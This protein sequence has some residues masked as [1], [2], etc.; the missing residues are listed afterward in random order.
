VI[1][2]GID[3]AG[4]GPTLG[5]LVMTSSSFRFSKPQNLWE[6]L[7]PAVRKARTG[8]I[9]S[10]WVQDS[11]LVKKVKNGLEQLE[12][13]VLSFFL[14]RASFPASFGEL[15]EGC[16]VDLRRYDNLPWYEGLL[17]KK[18][19]MFAWK[20][21]LIDKSRR[22]EGALKKA[23]IEFRGFVSHPVN[24]REFNNGIKRTNN[25]ATLHLEN[26]EHLVSA[27]LH[28]ESKDE[29]M[30]FICDKLGGRDKYS[31]V[32]GELFPGR[33]ISIHLE[34]AQQSHYSIKDG[35]RKIELRFM[36]KADSKSMSVALSSMVCKY[37][38]EVFVKAMNQHFVSQKP[39]LKVTAGYPKDARRYLDD[40]QDL[41]RSLEV[42]TEWL[43][44]GR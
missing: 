41:L 2:I 19:P 15:L 5:P 29:D 40:I 44:R 28:R 43:I 7:S 25:K 4:Y 33:V 26:L 12:I 34:G 38:R 9:H 20:G 17:E 16:D 37:V 31:R 6:A 10:I 24:A 30:S 14:T 42:P 23:E 39:D 8:P 3:E 11:K 36:Q 13:G 21:D 22:L 1:G 18:M 32:L 35:A 27:V